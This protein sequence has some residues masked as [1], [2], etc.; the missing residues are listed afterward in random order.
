VAEEDKEDGV[1]GEKDMEEADRSERVLT[2][3]KTNK[4]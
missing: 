3:S 2:T 4:R 1:A